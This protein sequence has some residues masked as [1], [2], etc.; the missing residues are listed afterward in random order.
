MFNLRRTMFDLY[1][2]DSYRNVIIEFYNI[3]IHYYYIYTHLF[4]LD[5]GKVFAGLFY[6]WLEIGDRFRRIPSSLN[7]FVKAKERRR[8]PFEIYP[9]ATK[10]N[11]REKLDNF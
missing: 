9:Y 10:G 6:K 4:C 2:R 1:T 3:I 8:Y 5:W 7:S 11:F